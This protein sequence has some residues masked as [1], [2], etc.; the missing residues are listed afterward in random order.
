MYRFRDVTL[1][2]TKRKWQTNEYSNTKPPPK[3]APSLSREG[4]GGSFL[5]G[6]VGVGLLL[7]AS[8]NPSPQLLVIKRVTPHGEVF[9]FSKHFN[10][11]TGSYC[12]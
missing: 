11:T 2:F 5:S 1:S 10:N 8:F 3:T 9:L 4:W 7:G 12:I 6:R